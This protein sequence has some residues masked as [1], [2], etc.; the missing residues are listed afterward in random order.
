M[1]NVRTRGPMRHPA[2]VVR[3]RAGE[4]ILVKADGSSPVA[5]NHTALALWQLCDGHTSVDEMVD[6]INYLYDADAV[7]LRHEVESILRQFADLD[8]V[9]WSAE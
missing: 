7:E 6:A 5:L 9:V 2:V 4:S 1:S 3:Q 8:L